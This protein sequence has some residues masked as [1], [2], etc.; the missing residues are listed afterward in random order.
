M[1]GH[2]VA[3]LWYPAINLYMC[4]VSLKE[5][6]GCF[7]GLRF[8]RQMRALSMSYSLA[9]IQ[10]HDFMESRQKTEN[11]RV[12]LDEPDSYDSGKIK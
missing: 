5:E 1:F 11:L 4:N 6:L 8:V 10:F 2:N 9:L 7:E 3:N 12:R